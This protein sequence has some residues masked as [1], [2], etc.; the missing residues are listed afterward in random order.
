MVK[1]SDLCQ[2]NVPIRG[3]SPNSAHLHILFVFDFELVYCHPA[4]HC[5]ICHILLYQESK[6]TPDY[7][8]SSNWFGFCLEKI[9]FI[10]ASFS[11]KNSGANT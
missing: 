7:T 3:S 2:Y 8:S 1:S 10:S 5:S 9:F 11:V 6:W 4:F